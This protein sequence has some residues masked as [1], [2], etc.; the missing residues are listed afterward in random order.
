MPK[1]ELKSSLAGN[2]LVVA[3]SGSL[4][5]STVT[6]LETDLNA[7]IGTHKGDFLFDLKGLEYI[8]SAGVGFFMQ[9]NDELNRKSSKLIFA[10]LTPKVQKVFT[11]L[12]LYKH[13]KIFD[14]NELA[15][16]ALK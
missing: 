3:I 9:K 12:N 1:I 7:A 14:N 6:P 4:D 5:A 13:F 10:G 11:V 16:A 8:S 15:L 2:V